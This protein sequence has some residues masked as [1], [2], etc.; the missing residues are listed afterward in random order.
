MPLGAGVALA[1]KYLGNNEICVCLYGDGAAN[2]AS[3]YARVECSPAANPNDI[4]ITFHTNMSSVLSMYCFTL[5]SNL[6]IMM[7]L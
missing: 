5:P 1:C 7:G 4:A 2:Q 3:H 6:C